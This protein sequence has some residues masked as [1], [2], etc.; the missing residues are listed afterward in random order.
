MNNQN[1]SAI[2]CILL[3]GMHGT[4]DLFSPLIE[5][6]ENFSS[7]ANNS[8]KLQHHAL[9][10]PIDIEQSYPN[11]LEWLEKTVDL[12]TEKIIVAESFSTPL[13][14][15]L[16]AN[17][18]DQIKAVVICAGFCASSASP[19][20]ALLPLRPLFMVS[21]PRAAVTHFLLGSDT[22]RDQV[23]L[24]RDNIKKI[25]AKPLSQ[26][27]RTILSLEESDTPVIPNTPVLLLQAQNDAVIPWEH[28]NQLEGH[29]PHSVTHWVDSPHLIL[30]TN[31][32]ECAEHILQFLTQLD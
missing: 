5:A 1:Q 2:E 22:S 3:P 17:H 27:V 23:D 19:S 4:A 28:Q 13:A 29:L 31:P 18:P 15:R 32:Q 21:P 20:L 6:L 7:R 26:R 25:P 24:I 10:Y 30:Q 9:S 16:A 14:L 12:S 11:L 8:I